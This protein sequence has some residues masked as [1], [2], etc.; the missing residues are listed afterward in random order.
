MELIPTEGLQCKK[1]S[2]PRNGEGENGEHV[3]F[4]YMTGGV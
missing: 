4:S 2:M 1:L 3:E